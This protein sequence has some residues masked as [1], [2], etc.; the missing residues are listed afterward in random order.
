MDVTL[1]GSIARTSIS[2]WWR[3]SVCVCV[4]ECVAVCTE[5]H[6]SGVSTLRDA[7]PGMRG[8]TGKYNSRE[9][10]SLWIEGKGEEHFGKCSNLCACGWMDVACARTW[11]WTNRTDMV[12]METHQVSRCVP[13]IDAM[14]L[15]S[16]H[17]QDVRAGEGARRMMLF[18]RTFLGKHTH[19]QFVS[20]L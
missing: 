14:S 13:P 18:S 5:R 4:C 9:V 10:L 15:P 17:H 7:R 11:M 3:L 12:N 6:D 20:L 16:I 1:V 19:T 8:K 2:Q